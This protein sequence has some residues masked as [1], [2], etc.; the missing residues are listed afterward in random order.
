MDRTFIQNP[1]LKW[2]GTFSLSGGFKIHEPEI[3]LRDDRTTRDLSDPPDSV[4]R[5]DSLPDDAIQ[6]ILGFHRLEQIPELFRLSRYYR[7]ILQSP[8]PALP[9]IPYYDNDA[10]NIFIQC[11]L[12]IL[13]DSSARLGLKW[14]TMQRLLNVTTV[15][16]EWQNGFHGSHMIGQVFVNWLK[17][18][19][20]KLD[21]KDTFKM[22]HG[23]NVA[24]T[25]WAFWI[26]VW[27]HFPSWCEK[28]WPRSLVK[29]AYDSAWKIPTKSDEEQTQEN[30]V[31]IE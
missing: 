20:R 28:M 2:T 1:D 31:K 4:N 10:C 22:V 25:M 15:Q 26:L 23:N 8:E 6:I 19:S 17:N 18:E 14:Q 30:A 27:E 13:G 12:T 21:A 24:E 3:E 9:I 11:G 29:H 5:L 16:R 7:K